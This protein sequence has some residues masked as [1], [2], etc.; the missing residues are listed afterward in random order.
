MHVSDT[1]A[2][3]EVTWNSEDKSIRVWDATKRTCLQTFR[4]E[5]DRFWI[6]GCQSKINLLA[7]GHDSDMIVL[8][9]ER[10]RPTSSVSG[11]SF[12]FIKNCFLRFYEYSTQ[13]E[14]KILPI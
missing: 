4:R 9:L 12:F 6:L 2:W 14:N 7:A 10:E 1:K 5:H 11:D 8:K 13:K 3:E